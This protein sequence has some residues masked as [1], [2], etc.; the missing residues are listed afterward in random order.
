SSGFRPTTLI[1]ARCR[2]REAFLNS[3]LLYALWLRKT[4]GGGCGGGVVLGGVTSE[5]CTRMHWSLMPDGVQILGSSMYLHRSVS[6]TTKG[7]EGWIKPRSP[8]LIWALFV[9]DSA[10]EIFS[11]N[12]AIG[13]WLP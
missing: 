4:S 13:I 1:W 6:S 10:G 8:E 2:K 7:G 3:M 5:S 9:G 12:L 11:Q